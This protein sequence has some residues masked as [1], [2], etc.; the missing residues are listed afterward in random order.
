[1]SDLL[2]RASQN[3]RKLLF[4][5]YCEANG[6]ILNPV[7]LLKVASNLGYDE[8]EARLIRILLYRNGWLKIV[9]KDNVRLTTEGCNAVK[10]GLNQGVDVPTGNSI[11]INNSTIANSNIQSATMNSS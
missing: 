6:S 10:R 7:D 3:G 5:I 2:R 1:M 8:N 9:D 4:K 11:T